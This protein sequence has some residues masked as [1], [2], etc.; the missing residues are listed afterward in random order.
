VTVNIEKMRA[1]LAP[2]SRRFAIRAI[3][4]ALACFATGAG[5]VVLVAHL[6]DP[7]LDC[8]PK[9]QLGRYDR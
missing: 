6:K 2:E 8:V 1:D 3:G 5:A 9:I 7:S 4:V